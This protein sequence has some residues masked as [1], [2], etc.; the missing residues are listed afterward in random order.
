MKRA[1]VLSFLGLVVLAGAAIAL[2]PQSAAEHGKE[3]YAVQKCALCHSIG[4]IGGSKSSLDGVGS[5]L[6]SEDLK[7][8]IRTPRQMKPSTIMKPY[9][10]LPEKDLN[11]LTAFLLSL[12]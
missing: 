8:W 9:P 6:S 10:N 11:D 12:R 3:V 5:R 2:S 1:L 7:K 4:G